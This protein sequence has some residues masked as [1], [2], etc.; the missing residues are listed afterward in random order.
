MSTRFITINASGRSDAALERVLQSTLQPVAPSAEYL[1]GLKN[2]LV[3]QFNQMPVKSRPNS[4]HLILIAAAGLLSSLMV[5]ALSIRSLIVLL[6][7]LGLLTQY[8]KN[9][10]KGGVLDASSVANR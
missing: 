10:N 1:R 2:M 4:D 5:V 6:S 3:K 9:L 7:A 8:K